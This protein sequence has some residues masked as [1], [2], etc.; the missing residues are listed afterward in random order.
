ME[1]MKWIWLPTF[2]AFIF[3]ALV[4]VVLVGRRERP[5]GVVI[6][7]LVFVLIHTGMLLTAYTEPRY[8]ASSAPFLCI[9]AAVCITYLG[10]RAIDAVISRRNIG[11][12]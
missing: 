5:S 10:S 4:G 1:S 7:W 2:G 11:I 9:F 6:G 3:T 8:Q 12:T